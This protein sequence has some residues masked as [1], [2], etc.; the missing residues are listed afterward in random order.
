MT[1][2]TVNGT[3]RFITDN[4]WSRYDSYGPCFCESCMILPI[5]LAIEDSDV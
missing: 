3:R 4:V 1:G 5:A 2:N